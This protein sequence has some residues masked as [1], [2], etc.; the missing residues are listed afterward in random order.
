VRACVLRAWLT[1]VSS[2]AARRAASESSSCA[3]RM[4]YQCVRACARRRGPTRGAAVSACRTKDIS[5]RK[6]KGEAILP[7][8]DHRRI[9]LRRS[10]PRRALPPSTICRGAISEQDLIRQVRHQHGKNSKCGNQMQIHSAT[11]TSERFLDVL[12]SRTWF[13][14]QYIVHSAALANS[15]KH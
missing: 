9:L 12:C 13:Q 11:A 4:P 8:R 3:E 10:D 6:R 1:V 15:R 5:E 7:V 14:S 2:Y